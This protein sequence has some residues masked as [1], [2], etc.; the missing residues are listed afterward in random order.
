MKLIL[1]P[2]GSHIS[3]CPIKVVLTVPVLLLLESEE[4][5]AAAVLAIQMCAAADDGDTQQPFRP[6]TEPSR[7]VMEAVERLRESQ[8][9]NGKVPPVVRVPW[10]WLVCHVLCC[11]GG[12][13]TI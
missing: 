4:H 13:I 2:L 5:M 8:T 10:P 7:E 3:A 1:Q 6:A 12:C 9:A 11:S